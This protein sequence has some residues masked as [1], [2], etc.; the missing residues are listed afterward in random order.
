M[1]PGCQ[2]KKGKGD[3]QPFPGDRLEFDLRGDQK[4]KKKI[5]EQTG[6]DR[7]TVE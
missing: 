4:K 5:R 1:A 3:R 6:Q 7:R 2:K